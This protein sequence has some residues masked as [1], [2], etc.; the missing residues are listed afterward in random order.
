MPV[1]PEERGAA[2]HGAS[3][4][5]NILSLMTAYCDSIDRGDLDG[6]AELFANGS[7]GIAGDLAEGSEA[8]RAVLNNV[9]LYDGT[10]R[11]RHL[12]SNVLITVDASGEK[13]VA[14]SCLTVMQ[15]VPPTFPLQ[16]IFVGT[17]NDVFAL[18]DGEWVFRERVIVPDLVGDMSC[19]RSDMA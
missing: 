14:T 9:T 4:D 5:S 8:V 13:A 17:Y 10:P 2:L 15:C 6:C 1:F 16:T 3:P 12:M 11:T 18:Q 19:H 7:W